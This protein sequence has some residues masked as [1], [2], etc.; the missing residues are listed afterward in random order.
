[1][2]GAGYGSGV[3]PVDS[4]DL[5]GTQGADRER[6]V[7]DAPAVLSIL[8]GEPLGEEVE[9]RIS[10]SEAFLGAVNLAEALGRLARAGLELGQAR[11]AVGA[12][13]VVVVPLDEGLA[14]DAGALAGLREG[15]SL[16]PGGRAFVALSRKLGA[17]GVT[18]ERAMEALDGIEVVRRGGGARRAGLA[19]GRPVGARTG[20]ADEDGPVAPTGENG[21]SAEGGHVG[22]E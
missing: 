12:L 18:T 10:G 17:V 14:Y 5:K 7:V 4:S 11:T 8:Y 22:L 16:S 6:L 15:N 19:Q 21:P 1:M 3:E 9:R 13:G 20:E 2:E